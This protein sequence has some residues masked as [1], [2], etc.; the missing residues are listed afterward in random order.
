MAFWT[1]TA[2]IALVQLAS[3]VIIVHQVAFLSVRL[4]DALLAA[5]VAGAVGPASLPG[6]FVLNRLGDRFTSRVQLLRPLRT[7]KDHNL[8]SARVQLFRHTTT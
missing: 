2:A 7:P 3:R 8:R 1:L 5:S 4:G 6:R